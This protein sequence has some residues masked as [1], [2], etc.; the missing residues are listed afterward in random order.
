[1]WAGLLHRVWAHFWSFDAAVALCTWVTALA[2]AGFT[3]VA[4]SGPGA[5][6]WRGFRDFC[7]PAT[8]L[9]HPSCRRDVMFIA[10]SHFIRLPAGVMVSNLVAAELS[11]AGL[12]A[13]LGA[14]PRHAE[15]LWLWFAILAT[16]VV[17]QDAMTFVAHVLQ[18]RM[19]VFWELH[20]VHHSAEFL[21]PLSN[22][23]FHPLQAIMDDWFTMLPLGLFLGVTSYMFAL[24]VHDNS[25]I[26]LD[27]L[28]VMNMLS[29]YHLRH[30]HVQM[31]YGW[32]ERHLISPAQHQLH[33]SCEERHWDK[34]FGFCFAWWDRIYGTLIYSTPGE[35][36]ALG[37]PIGEQQDYDSVLKLFLTPL[38]NLGHM[39][40]RGVRRLPQEV[41]AEPAVSAAMPSVQDAA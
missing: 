8:L 7:L 26:G 1:M 6:T 28:F 29:F 14:Q 33:H 31:R 19:G 13:L 12:S 24:P 20:K 30:S 39:A 10:A 5:R 2:A 17:L 11:Y 15:P 3:Y 25:I 36:F 22:R 21:I 34:N 35:Q 9:R 41:G 4:Q 27:A 40:W 38:W 18:H 23:R 32:L 16:G 37:L